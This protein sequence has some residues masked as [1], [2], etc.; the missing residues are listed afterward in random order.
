MA[1]FFILHTEIKHS[2]TNFTLLCQN[3][4]IRILY[5]L[6]IVYSLAVFLSM[7]TKIVLEGYMTINPSFPVVNS[8]SSNQNTV[9]IGYIVMIG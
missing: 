7:S 3:C 2:N 5:L 9:F 8:N 6:D 1:D 4:P